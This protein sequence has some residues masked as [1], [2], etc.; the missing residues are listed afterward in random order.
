ML[1]ACISRVATDA[2]SEG[3]VPGDLV[4]R[5]LV[6]RALFHFQGLRVIRLEGFRSR[7]NHRM[8]EAASSPTMDHCSGRK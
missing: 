5:V 3:I 1:S 6:R 4:Q 7:Q 8:S 2:A